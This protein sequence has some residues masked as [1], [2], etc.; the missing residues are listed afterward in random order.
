MN[1]QKGDNVIVLDAQ[2][3]VEGFIMSINKKSITVHIP[4]HGMLNARDKRIKNEDVE[5]K[6]CMP[7]ERI[8]VLMTMP[9]ERYDIVRDS[10][11]LEAHLQTQRRE[12]RKTRETR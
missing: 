12:I 10:F 11:S 6:I 3:L 9:Q 4:A 8:Y 1:Y 2:F 7:D 5:R